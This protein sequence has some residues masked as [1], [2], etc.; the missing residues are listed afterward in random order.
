LIKDPEQRRSIYKA[1][2]DN[3]DL[4]Q[5]YFIELNVES[6]A[7]PKIDFLTIETALEEISAPT[8]KGDLSRSIIGL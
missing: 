3:F 6:N 5:T 4:I 2:L 1:L 7:Y 8:G